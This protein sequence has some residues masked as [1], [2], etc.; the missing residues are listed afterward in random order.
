[1]ACGC[2]GTDGGCGSSLRTEPP[3]VE[4]LDMT[5]V[6]AATGNGV[7]PEPAADA[8]DPV[9]PAGAVHLIASSEQ[10]WPRIRVNGVPVTPE[11]LGQEIQYHPAGSRDEAVYLAARALVIRALL[12]E[13]I[14]ALGLCVAPAPG[15]SEEEAATQALLE[16]EVAVPVVQDADVERYYAQNRARFMSPPL[17][18]VRHILLAAAPDDP[19]ARSEQREAAQALIVALQEGG[20]FAT[21]AGK[22]SVCPSKAQG[23]ALGQISRGQTVPEFER[24]LFRLPQG[25]AT[26]P[27]ESRYG[28]HVVDVQQR[29][30]GEQLPLAAVAGAIRREL[31]QRV[32]QKAV[33]QYL[34]MLV[35]EADI[36]GISLDGAASPLM[37]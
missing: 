9:A 8:V 14:L 34:Q 36:E 23:G 24:Q 29:V 13:R 21:L 7:G 20:D 26:Q 2:G 37:Q 3:A 10:E 5:P 22:V 33:T 18:M 35:G 28:W 19:E 4:A 15:E 1:M 17:V 32:W 16:R 12:Q 25:L 6:A 30:E 27:L 11:A 31:E